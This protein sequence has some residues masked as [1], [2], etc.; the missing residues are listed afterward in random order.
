MF[1]AEV[2]RYKSNSRHKCP[3]KASGVRTNR[4]SSLGLLF[5]FDFEPGRLKR[6]RMLR[7]AGPPRV[8]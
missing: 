1:V 8:S 4:S 7:H 3:G 6:E 5:P 2:N